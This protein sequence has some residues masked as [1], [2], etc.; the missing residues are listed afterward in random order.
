MIIQTAPA[1]LEFRYA[2]DKVVNLV[3]ANRLPTPLS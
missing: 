1:L 2:L 3:L